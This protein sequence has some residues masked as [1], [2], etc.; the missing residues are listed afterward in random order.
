MLVENGWYL[1]ALVA[2]EM[3]SV[4]GHGESYSEGEHWGILARNIVISFRRNQRKE[5]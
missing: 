2:S 3:R 1:V 5:Y 4:V